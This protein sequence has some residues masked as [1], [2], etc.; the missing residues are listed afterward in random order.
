MD[1]NDKDIEV[2]NE[3]VPTD[4]PPKTSLE[5]EIA[6][7][8]GLVFTS[9]VEMDCDAG[10]LVFESDTADVDTTPAEP[11]PEEPSSSFVPDAFGLNVTYVPR[12]TEASEN[13]RVRSS[14][15]ATAKV[16]P[17]PE[18]TLDPT[19]EIGEDVAVERVVVTSTPAP[20]L[21]PT[22]ESIK[23]Y[24]FEPI[25]DPDEEAEPEKTEPTP[26]V[27]EIVVPKVEPPVEEEPAHEEKVIKKPEE[28][29]IPD[30]EVA[31][32]EVH[33]ED[34]EEDLSASPD[35]RFAKKEFISPAQRDAF[36]DR[37]LDTLM[38]VR[39]RLVAAILLFAAL[40][41]V[42]IMRVWNPAVEPLHYIGLTSSYA[43]VMMD[44]MASVCMFALVLPEVLRAI[45]SLFKRVVAP[46]L[47]MIIS[48]GTLVA[49][50]LVVT[51]NGDY[52]QPRFGILF[53]IQVTVALIASLKKAK[54]DF[55]AFK[56]VSKNTHKHVLIKKLT[57]ELP[58]ENMALDGVVDEYSSKTA[59][60]FR[61][62][63]VNDFCANSS[64]PLENNF[65]NLIIMGAT[66]GIAAVT[67]VVSYFLNDNSASSAMQALVLVTLVAIP[68]FSVLVHKLPYLVAAKH[69]SKEDIAFVGEHALYDGADF[70]VIAYE[71]TEVFGAEDVTISKV[72][73][74]G[75]VINTAKAM[76]QMYAIFSGVGGPLNTLFSAA[77][78]SKGSVATDLIF[79]ADGIIGT[80]DG[81]T[82]AAGTEEFMH[83][84]GIT[85]PDDDYRTSRTSNDSTRIMY[86]AE[87][88][89]VYVK[90]FIRYSFTEEFT[91]I[92]PYLKEQGIVPLIYT[93]DPNVNNDL[94]KNLTMGDDVIRVMKKDGG[95]T[96]EEKTYRHLSSGIVTLSDRTTVVSIAQLSRNYTAFQSTISVIELISMIVGAALAALVALGGMISV[97]AIGLVGGLAVWQA[98]WCIVLEIR[99]R[100]AIKT[101]VNVKE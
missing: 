16:E 58:R 43:P 98:A 73:L 86:G 17:T 34:A 90:F 91:M 36:K 37:L 4:D 2:F 101:T 49:Y 32:T 42:E 24:K 35:R 61:T 74:Y 83:R 48:L 66:V 95:K 10:G 5:F 15:P 67:S 97:S 40:V 41:G 39:F 64:S 55:I 76:Q 27:E 14:R 6:E 28:Y 92:L 72:H 69:A 21:E 62:A 52:N 77:V 22:D 84:K 1:I 3:T 46:E 100:R 96:T 8:P 54:A 13:Y 81:H 45:T 99:S 33:Y 9:E 79:E 30:P 44:L 51:K 29:T 7:A 80:V 88:G 20:S 68:A 53:A 12:F 93:R 60:M 19:A 11:I 50:T 65:N 38:A 70:D 25:S 26:E 85:I 78:D 94:L 82:V 59:R 31:K 23:V 71:D 63:F 57:R 18:P 75:K 89:E 47:F 87:D 56:L